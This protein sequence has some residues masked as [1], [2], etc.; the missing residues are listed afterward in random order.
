MHVSGNGGDMTLWKCGVWHDHHEKGGVCEADLES[1]V[2]EAA[3]KVCAYGV[4][5]PWDAEG[6]PLYNNLAI[7]VDALLAARGESQ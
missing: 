5:D 4:I 3:I 6:L 1:A 2:V 7:A